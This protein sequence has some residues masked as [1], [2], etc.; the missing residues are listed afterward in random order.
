MPVESETKGKA[1]TSAS[2]IPEMTPN[3]EVA[4][5]SMKTQLLDKG[6]TEVPLAMT[7][8]LWLKIKVYAEGGENRLHA[9]P[10]QDHSFIVLQGRARFYGPEGES[11]ECGPNEGIMLPAGS[12]YHFCNITDQPL[13]LLRIGATVDD[14][15]HP[16]MRII[17]GD[18]WKVRRGRGA[19]YISPD[20]SYRKGDFF[21]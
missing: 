1:S 21:G 13:V 19:T 17:N 11:R 2:A 20:V 14:G 10:H 8:K 16:D 15:K 7:D 12:F 18:E 9:H 5:F 3:P 4:F 6:N